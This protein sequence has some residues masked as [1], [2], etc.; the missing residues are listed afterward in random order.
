MPKLYLWSKDM[1]E[2]DD[3]SHTFVKWRDDI[4]R[5]TDVLPASIQKIE[6]DSTVKMKDVETLVYGLD[7][8][9][10][11]RLPN[12]KKVIFHDAIAETKTEKL[13][14]KAWKKSCKS[15]E[16]RLQVEQDV[17]CECLLNLMG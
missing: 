7:N 3:D 5:L 2:D 11:E 14:E 1:Y 13:I 16:V 8:C 15:V 4:P 9:K 10:A 12:L 6:F 17:V